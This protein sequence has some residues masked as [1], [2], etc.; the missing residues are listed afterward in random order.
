[1]PIPTGN[2][3]RPVLNSSSSFESIVLNLHSRH[4]PSCNSFNKYQHMQMFLFA[5]KICRAILKIKRSFYSV[6][7]KLQYVNGSTL[8][9]KLNVVKSIEVL[10]HSWGKPV[11]QAKR[12]GTKKGSTRFW[13]HLVLKVSTQQTL[14]LCDFWFLI[15]IAVG[16]IVKTK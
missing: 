2:N 9:F 3:Y 10:S 6:N 13:V 4:L 1:M 5:N 11:L 15:L 16:K 14:L 12:M 8:K 7:L